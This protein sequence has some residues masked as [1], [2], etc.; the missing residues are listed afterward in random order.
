MPEWTS[1]L[2]L[3]IHLQTRGGRKTNVELHLQ[4]QT[5]YPF[6]FQWCHETEYVNPENYRYTM[7]IIVHLSLSR[8]VL[9]HQFLL[10]SSLTFTREVHWSSCLSAGESFEVWGDLGSSSLRSIRHPCTFIVSSSWISVPLDIP[11]N[12]CIKSLSWCIYLLFL[13]HRAACDHFW[14]HVM[15]MPRRRQGFGVL[16]CCFD[17]TFCLTLSLSHFCPPPVL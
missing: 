14:H 3:L 1:I 7:H 8:S 17:F 10:V 4:C 11:H 9:S 5:T 6:L 13:S 15:M 16:D 12:T 2:H